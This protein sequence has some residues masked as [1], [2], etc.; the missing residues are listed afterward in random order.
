MCAHTKALWNERYALW[1]DCSQ[2]QKLALAAL[3]PLHS[4]L[5]PF[6][7]YKNVDCTRAKRF[8]IFNFPAKRFSNRACTKKKIFSC[9]PPPPPHCTSPSSSLPKARFVWCTHKG[10]G[11]VWIHTKRKTEQNARGFTNKYRNY[12]PQQ[13]LSPGLEV[14]LRCGGGRSSRR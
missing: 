8:R 2:Q 6:S 14:L 7:K 5:P 1:K 10:F 12:F 9:T 4:A 11:F 13:V 3:I